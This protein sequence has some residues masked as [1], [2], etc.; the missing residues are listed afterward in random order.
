MP[1]FSDVEHKTPLADELLQIRASFLSRL[2]YQ[3]YNGYVMS[4]FKKMQTDIRNQ[5]RVKW[6]H[7]MHLIRLLISGIT[8][9]VK[10]TF[11]FESMSTVIDC[12]PLSEG[13]CRGK[14][15]R[16]GDS[17]CMKSLAMHLNDQITGASRLRT[18]Q[19][20]SDQ[21]TAR[22]N[23]GCGR[24]NTPA[25]VVLYRPVGQAEF[26]LI[27]Q[28]D[29]KHFP[30]RLPSQ[31]IFYPVLREEYAIRIARD[32]NTKDPNSQFIGYVLRFQVRKEYLDQ[33]EPYS[34][35][36]RALMEYWI[37]AAEL[38]E[39][40]RNIVGAIEMV[41]EFKS[42]GTPSTSTND[43]TVKLNSIRIRCC[44]PRSAGRTLRLSVARF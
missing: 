41:H 10:A 18:G 40:N 23:S 37:P 11:R 31:P 34:A 13:K 29:W 26:D 16:S 24:M 5:G 20:V 9:C 22:G 35:G 21:G 43:F 36:G 44:S 14:M 2:V 32:W 42:D 33:F 25:T 3:T 39:F 6:K 28:S 7:V 1:L 19:R 17:A 4:Q 30:P 27:R 15:P 8:I 12:W 38:D